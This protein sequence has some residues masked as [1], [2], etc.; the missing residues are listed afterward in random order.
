[1][2]PANIA[3]ITPCP[4]LISQ[5]N[6]IY[7]IIM[8]TYRRLVVVAALV[9][10]GLLALTA[11]SRNASADFVPIGDIA[12][13]ESY[14][15]YASQGELLL[16]FYS[17]LGWHHPGPLY[18]YLL[19]PVH[20]LSGGRSTGIFAAAVG[21]NLLA[22]LGILAVTARAAPT[23]LAVA[24]GGMTVLYF[25]RIA[26]ILANPWT[27][28]V[29]IVPTMALM[30]VCAAVMDRRIGLLPVAAVLASLIAQTHVGLMPVV[31]VT[32]VTAAITAA[33]SAVRARDSERRRLTAVLGVT[34]LALVAAWLLPLVEQLTSSHGNFG[35]LWDF[36]VREES[37]GQSFRIA[38]NAWS[39]MLAALVRPDFVPYLESPYRARGIAWV[40][41]WASLQIL[42]LAVM[43]VVANRAK[44][45]FEAAL[46]V[47]LLS[48]SLVALWSITRI[49]GPPYRYLVVWVSGIGAL[50]TALAIHAVAGLI[51]RNQPVTARWNTVVCGGLFVA[52]ALIG[53]R[54]VQWEI[55]RSFR[56]S[57]RE[58]AGRRFAER[59]ETYTREPGKGKPLI[60]IDQSAW[61]VAAG[62]ILKLQ[63]DQFP[64]A[65]ETAW[66]P[67]FTPVV[68]AVGDEIT[69]VRFTDFQTLNRALAEP[70]HELIGNRESVY[71]VAGP[72]K[73]QVQ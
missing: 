5:I 43:A 66:L 38:F 47:L 48:A 20:A 58:L 24:V 8:L 4:A 59:V 51:L 50:N 53:V 27:P 67:M 36:F 40:Q 55:R 21:I 3:L 45:R 23:G 12:L 32:S 7:Q 44:N 64:F 37:S 49:D 63:R 61:E 33:A 42:F 11:Y 14:T 6:D 34:V 31:L 1:M 60:R 15:R 17:R 10:A 13:I 52:A 22:L 28:F 39:D 72:L 54:Q 19:A 35:Q 69:V 18:F 70:G 2:K 41:V 65:V 57:L 46:A 25:W 56:P 16:G 29:V 73:G 71:V 30:V 26:Q 62:A 68:A 9:T